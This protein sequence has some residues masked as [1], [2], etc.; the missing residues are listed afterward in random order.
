VA[1][2]DR[3]RAGIEAL[4]IISQAELARRVGMSPQN[5]QRI[6]IGEVKRSRHFRRIAEELHC[7]VGWLMSGTGK[8]PRWWKPEGVEA[9]EDAEHEGAAGVVTSSGESET[10]RLERALARKELENQQLRDEIAKLMQDDRQRQ[11]VMHQLQE[12]IA[13]LEARKSPGPVGPPSS[14]GAR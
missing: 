6:L 2:G 5:L 12:R 14:G 10:A 7:S 4:G 9:D 11:A 8:P 3:I 13:A 1:T